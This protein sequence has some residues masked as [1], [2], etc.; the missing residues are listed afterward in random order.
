MEQ[1]HRQ[2]DFD[3]YVHG[4]M[5]TTSNCD[6]LARCSS[7]VSKTLKLIRDFVLDIQFVF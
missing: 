6:A 5:A 1:I 7:I 4:H 3:W 2:T